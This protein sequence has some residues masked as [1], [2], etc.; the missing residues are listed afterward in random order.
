MPIDARKLSFD[1][2]RPPSKLLAKPFLRKIL[3]SRAAISV[4]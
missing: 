2:E 4:M 3:S 1:F